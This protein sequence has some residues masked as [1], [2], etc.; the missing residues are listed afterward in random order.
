VSIEF[1]GSVSRGAGLVAWGT[2]C[3][4]DVSGF[5]I[6]TVDN[7]GNRTRLNE[8]IVPC[9]ECVT[10]LGASYFFVVPKHKSGRD[11]FIEQV[12]RDGTTRDFGPAVRH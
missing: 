9:Q 3:E 10:G 4:I 5:N 6:V 11:L 8:V 2:N 12:M 1:N 7:R